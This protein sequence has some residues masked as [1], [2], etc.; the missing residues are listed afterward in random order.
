LLSWSLPPRGG[1][2]DCSALMIQQSRQAVRALLPPLKTNL[3]TSETVVGGNLAK[4]KIKTQE[5]GNR[6]L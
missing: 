5:E 6:G 2:T 4:E 1:L 3:P